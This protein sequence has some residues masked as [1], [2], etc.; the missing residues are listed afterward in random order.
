[1][2]KFPFL[3]S[4]L[5]CLHACSQ[6]GDYKVIKTYHITSAGGW[7]YIAVNNGKIYVSHGTQVNVLN[8]A[9]G[10][11]IGC[12]PHTNGV[13]GIAFNNETGRG[14]TSNGRSNT[15]TVFDLKTND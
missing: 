6:S 11:S 4:I 14:Y 7:D 5:I 15:V 3:L 13:H 8:E 9:S 1:M 10:D 12:I 2:K